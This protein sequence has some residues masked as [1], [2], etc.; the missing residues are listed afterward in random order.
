MSSF[1]MTVKNRRTG[2][3][4]TALAVDDYFGK[5]NYGY[6]LLSGEVLRESAFNARYEA[7]NDES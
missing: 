5:H 7:K 3:T 4:E 6:M 1:A 2:D